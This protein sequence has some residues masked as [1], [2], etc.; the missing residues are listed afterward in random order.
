[1]AVVLVMSK[2]KMKTR[3]CFVMIGLTVA[4]FCG[5]VNGL[6]FNLLPYSKSAYAATFSPIVEELFKMLPIVVC[7]FAVNY[8]R[9][10]IIENSIAV[11][12]GFAMLENAYVFASSIDQ[13]TLLTAVMRAFG[14]G[15]MHVMTTLLMGFGLSF[16]TDRRKL[17][18]AGPIALLATTVIYHSI[19]N[20]LVSGGFYIAGFLMPAVLVIP[21]MMFI[22][23]VC[24]EQ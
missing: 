1:M 2:S 3:V 12:V 24:K 22:K 11:G 19:Y 20:Y 9:Q 13:I 14:S 8:G 6:L 23:K 21:T 4:L 15:I 10:N 7:A 18:F 17:Y 16:V 5:E